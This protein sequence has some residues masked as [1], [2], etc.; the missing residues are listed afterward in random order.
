MA[1]RMGSERRG[2]ARGLE[3]VIQHIEKYWCP[4]ILG[5]SSTKVMPG[6]AGPQRQGTHESD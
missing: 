6:S 1:R 3:L 4:S 5:E 2:H